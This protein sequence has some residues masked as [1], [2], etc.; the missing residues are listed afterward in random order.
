MTNSTPFKWLST[1][2]MHLQHTEHWMRIF[3]WH[4]SLWERKGR[5]NQTSYV[6]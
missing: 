2:V 5:I 4:M 1:W 3:P 6:S